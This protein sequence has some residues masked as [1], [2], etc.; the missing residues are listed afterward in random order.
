MVGLIITES[1]T[2]APAPPNSA[3]FSHHQQQANSGNSSSGSPSSPNSSSGN[4]SKSSTSN[5]S[6]TN[7]SNSSS[8][9]QNNPTNTTT[10]LVN[11]GPGNI[12]ELFAVASIAGAISYRQFLIRRKP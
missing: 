4:A 7:N 8:S 1:K 3:T 5:S 12:V 6:S 10:P 11:T 9:N 2:S